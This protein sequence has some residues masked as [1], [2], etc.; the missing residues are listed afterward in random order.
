MPED[1][2]DAKDHLLSNR[3]YD[4]LKLIALILLPALGTLYFGLAGI[5]NL[6]NAQEVSSTVVVLV[7]FLGVVIKIGD[8]T[9]NKSEAKYDGELV[10]DESGNAK[11][12]VQ[13][14]VLSDDKTDILLKVV[15]PEKIIEGEIDP[16]DPRD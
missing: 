9:Y 1:S 7:T 11:R 3:L 15:T 13:N 12:V 14:G 8:S 2:T 16:W 5:W 10:F 6:P 4:R